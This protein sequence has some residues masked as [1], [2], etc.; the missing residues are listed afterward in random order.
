MS[1]DLQTRDRIATELLADPRLKTPARRCAV[2]TR[3]A[4]DTPDL[5]PLVARECPAAAK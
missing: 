1:D 3:T 4:W 2:L 5:K